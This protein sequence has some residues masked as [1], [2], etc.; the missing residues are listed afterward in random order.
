MRCLIYDMGQAPPQVDMPSDVLHWIFPHNHCTH[1]DPGL[2]SADDWYRGSAAH[3]GVKGIGRGWW[4]ERD[5]GEGIGRRDKGRKSSEDVS[6][7]TFTEWKQRQRKYVR[8]SKSLEGS[9]SDKKHRYVDVRRE[10]HDS[11]CK[12]TGSC[13]SRLIFVL[14]IE[15]KIF[16]L[17]HKWKAGFIFQD[18]E[19]SEGLTQ[20]VQDKH[21]CRHWKD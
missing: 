20:N 13:H 18:A 7:E 14:I 12:V 8:K 16:P 17:R 3:S 21:F 9:G 5:R 6:Q 15:R 11:W 2:Q 10:K 1:P 4:R 19:L